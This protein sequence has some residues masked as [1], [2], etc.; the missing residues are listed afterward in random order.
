MSIMFNTLLRE[1]V[2]TLTDVRLIRHKDTRDDRPRPIRT[3]AR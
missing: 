3:L 1:V 2:T